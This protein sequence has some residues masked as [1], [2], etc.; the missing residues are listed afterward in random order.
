MMV[1]LRTSATQTGIS[2]NISRKTLG[3]NKERTWEVLY[4][5]PPQHQEPQEPLA[6]SG[7]PVHFEMFK[8]MDKTSPHKKCRKWQKHL[9]KPEKHPTWL[10]LCFVHFIVH[11]LLACWRFETASLASLLASGTAGR[12]GSLGGWLGEGEAFMAVPAHLKENTWM[13]SSSLLNRLETTFHLLFISSLRWSIVATVSDMWYVQFHTKIPQ[14]SLMAF[15][16]LVATQAAAPF[17]K[18]I[19]HSLLA[20]QWRKGR[21]TVTHS[22]THSVTHHGCLNSNLTT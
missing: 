21:L 11:S 14:H 18:T 7:S 6:Q 3:K 22:F 2:F 8:V 17:Q 13:S 1:T 10:N 12:A 16:W 5:F 4:Q 19:K 9:Q 20:K 15:G